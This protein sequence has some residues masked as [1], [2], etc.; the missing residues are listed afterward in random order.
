MKVAEFGV[1]LRG[2]FRSSD[3]GCGFEDP[4]PVRP[5]DCFLCEPECGPRGRVGVAGG[6]EFEIAY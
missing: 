2:R 5:E 1:S 4:G 3:I 6:R